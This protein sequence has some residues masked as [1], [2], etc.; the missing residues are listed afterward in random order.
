MDKSGLYERGAGLATVF[1]LSALD[2]LTCDEHDY[3]LQLIRKISAR[4]QG[5]SVKIT[6]EVKECEEQ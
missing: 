4:N 6:F 2:I 5:C 1:N 3:M